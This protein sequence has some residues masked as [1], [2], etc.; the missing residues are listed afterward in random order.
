MTGPRGAC[1]GEL[2]S[3]A[4]SSRWSDEHVAIESFVCL[5]RGVEPEAA[6][7]FVANDDAG[8]F[9]VEPIDRVSFGHECAVRRRAGVLLLGVEML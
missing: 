6:L 1:A 8:D 3:S 7:A 2:A 5:G 9:L 4:L